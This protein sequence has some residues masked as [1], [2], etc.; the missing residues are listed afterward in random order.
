LIEGREAGYELYQKMEKKESEDVIYNWI[1]SE[2]GP[3]FNLSPTSKTDILITCLLQAGHKS[4]SHLIIMIERYINLWRKYI[5]DHTT[6]LQAITST[7]AFYKTSPQRII[8]SLNK[9]VTFRVIPP[10]AIVE[11]LFSDD[12]LPLLRKQWVWELLFVGI[13]QTIDTLH[14]LQKKLLETE[15]P[16][17]FYSTDEDRFVYDKL[18]VNISAVEQEQKELFLTLFQRFEMIL[19]NYSDRKDIEDKIND[20]TEKI[21]PDV[22]IYKSATEEVVMQ[23]TQLTSDDMN[24]V[25]DK[26]T[27]INKYTYRIL[28]GVFKIVGRKYYKY[29]IS[30]S[31]TLDILL[32]QTDPVVSSV[33]QSW[34]SVMIYNNYNNNK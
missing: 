26:S 5:N 6:A 30:L 21:S 7:V 25:K 18:K 9:L 29:L 1:E 10:S 12:V 19:K 16:D 8:I 15:N 24:E 13:D 22:E 4:F 28:L 20:I 23:E 27:Y 31:D 11:W 14:L 3:M 32:S 2:S 33:Y 34:K 17:E